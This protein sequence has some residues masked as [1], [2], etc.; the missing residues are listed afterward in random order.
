MAAYTPLSKTS[1]W[2]DKPNDDSD[3]RWT[4][5]DS[6]LEQS[7]QLQ[8][9]Q[10]FYQRNWKSITF[11]CLTL[12]SNIGTLLT[13]WHWA[14]LGCPYGVYGPDLVYSEYRPSPKLCPLNI[15][16]VAPARSAIAY[17]SQT[18]DPTNI[19][20]RNGSVNPGRLHKEF[21]PPSPS[22]D[23]AWEE[24]IQCTAS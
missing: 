2:T 16:C 24:L 15:T 1:S 13:A 8:P 20:F 10:S 17:E 19:F 23:N 18:W 11:L 22:S 14:R 7:Q 4:D 3:G 5:S 6:F 21:G 12:I 9:R